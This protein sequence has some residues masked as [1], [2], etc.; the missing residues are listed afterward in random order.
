MAH[1][2]NEH[3]IPE[4]LVVNTNQAQDVLAQGSNFTWA[5]TGLKQVSVVGAE[6][7]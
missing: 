5:K 6:E 4:E 2:I 3:D 7:K 1:D